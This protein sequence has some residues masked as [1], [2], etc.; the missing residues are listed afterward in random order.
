MAQTRT[1]NFPQD[2]IAI[3]RRSEFWLLQ[4]ICWVVYAV[5][6]FLLLVGPENPA[7]I[8]LFLLKIWRSFLGFLAALA[9]YQIMRRI[10]RSSCPLSLAAA[11]GLASS[12]VLGFT[13]FIAFRLTVNLYVHRSLTDW[14]FLRYCRD[15]IEQI[16]ILLTCC[17]AYAA[18]TYWQDALNQQR[19]ADAAAASAERLRW[20]MLQSQVNP[21]FLF[22]TLNS[23][24]ASISEDPEQARRMVTHL[25]EFLRY[26]L[27]SEERELVSLNEEIAIVADYL[28]IEKA[29]Y[30][31]RLR[32]TYVVQPDAKTALVP[33]FLLQP[34]VE[35][36][37][38]HGLVTSNR[39]RIVI[40][41]SL[42]NNNL[43][44]AV[45]NSGFWLAAPNTGNGIGFGLRNLRERLEVL[46]GRNY[47]LR[48]KD[49][50]NKVQVLV[51]FPVVQNHVWNARLRQ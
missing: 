47:E 17:A 32:V 22:N 49:K 4:A 27:I 19:R 26:S 7:S 30:E 38:K 16:A 15:S 3:E 45:E 5:A 36:A 34:L 50:N 18:V 39:L 31:D 40:R 1:L 48:M 23:V 35:N 14:S 42:E 20:Q 6:A 2:S 11:V 28:S 51:T 13:W 37:V 24:R 12:G 21:H 41:A 43:Q 8:S 9:V 46:F 29:R 44:I 33:R 10:L 25:S